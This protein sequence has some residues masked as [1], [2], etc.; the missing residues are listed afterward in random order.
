MSATRTEGVTVG[1]VLK[2]GEGEPLLSGY[3]GPASESQQFL[4]QFRKRPLSN[5][6]IKQC[7]IRTY[8]MWRSSVAHLN[9]F[10]LAAS[11][12]VGRRWSD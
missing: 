1:F 9:G 5:R 7:E 12:G 4:A 8:G 11:V 6:R 2:T 3:A 10:T